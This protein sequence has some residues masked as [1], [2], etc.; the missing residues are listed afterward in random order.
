M[1]K[2]CERERTH[3]IASLLRETFQ[4]SLRPSPASMH[5][6]VLLLLLV[7]HLDRAALATS[8]GV[9]GS[10]MTRWLNQNRSAER[11]ATDAAIATM[12][13]H[14]R[15]P[16]RWIATGSLADGVPAE[17]DAYESW[18]DALTA[19]V[20]VQVYGAITIQRCPAAFFAL[21]DETSL[22]GIAPVATAFP[23]PLTHDYRDAWA[24]LM[25]AIP[26]L[27]VDAQ[28]SLLQHWDT[29][30][31]VET[32][33]NRL[34]QFESDQTVHL[35]CAWAVS[36]ADKILAGAATS[37]R[38]QQL[39]EDIR[40]RGMRLRRHGPSADHFA[41]LSFAARQAS[42]VISAPRSTS[43]GTTRQRRPARRARR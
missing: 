36:W 12:S 15:A 22:R 21:L 30:A 19:V 1:S 32:N 14:L 26:F 43:T 5:R 11:F 6:R 37:A 42:A 27:P 38:E 40:A 24:E 29:I 9:P 3:Q 31:A 7:R 39:A 23:G 17:V 25:R 34:F 20:A 8:L 16:A 18:L 28:A 33:P 13:T 4:M 10:A 41:A 2:R 35:A